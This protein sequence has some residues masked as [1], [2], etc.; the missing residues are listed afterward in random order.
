MAMDSWE[1]DWQRPNHSTSAAEGKTNLTSS[2]FPP[3]TNLSNAYGGGSFLWIFHENATTGPPPHNTPPARVRDVALAHA[4]IAVLS[5]ILA[6]TTLGNGFVLWVLLRR[7]KHRA[8]MHLFMVNLCVA[9]LVVAFFQ[10]LPQL[11][12]DITER[13]QGPDAVCRSVKYLQIVGMF[14][15]SYIIV[16]MTVDR[17][18]A[19]CCPMQAYRDGATSSWNTPV[20]VA[21]GL[22]LLFSLPQVFIF[23][24]SEVAPGMF[25]CW[26]HFIE[27]W[28]HKAY[29]IWMTV[30][31][32]V[33]PAIIITV[34]QVRIFK[35]IH[36]NI[37]LKS[38][39]VVTAEYKK[40]SMFLRFRSSR[41]SQ[42]Q[43]DRELM[44]RG[45]RGGGRGGNKHP[46]Q[47]NSNPSCSRSKF[48]NL[49][50]HAPQPEALSS[51]EK[52]S[53][54]P[55]FGNLPRGHLSHST[56]GHDPHPSQCPL[57]AVAP[58]DDQTTQSLL[59]CPGSSEALGS[60]PLVAACNLTRNTSTENCSPND[61]HSDPKNSNELNNA[62]CIAPLEYSPVRSPLSL[63]PPGISKA[64]SKTVRM[65]LVIVLVYTICWSPF[66]IVQL[67]AAWDPNPPDQGAAFTI[68]MLLASLNS[69]TNPWIYTAFS[70]SVSNELRALLRCRPQTSRRSSL[71]DD[72]TTTHTSTTAMD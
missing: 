72:S 5:L 13:F 52:T 28:G 3:S 65:T 35:E 45:G 25:E 30:A 32:F 63:P 29:V 43:V 7:R 1:P 64:M 46:Q 53:D 48:D 69:C 27:P 34:C 62:S 67:W 49:C 44:R 51:S 37:Y 4:E 59:S 16:A 57:E 31:V 40:S 6:L 58:N 8:P 26:G 23:S 47:N 33:M 15:S 68:L 50:D 60:A 70:S 12:W 9:D 36:D 21:W 66:F 17:H 20:M 39:R 11:I 56:S 19:I 71:P 41:D 54:E 2:L 55:S 14:A 61:T 24:M 38:E 22:S 10:V 18:Y 42:R